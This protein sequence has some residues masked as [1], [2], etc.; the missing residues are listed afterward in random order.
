MIPATVRASSSSQLAHT[1]GDEGRGCSE[2][3]PRLAQGCRQLGREKGR[4]LL[5][6]MGSGV[7]SLPTQGR[8]GLNSITFTPTQHQNPSVSSSNLPL[9]CAG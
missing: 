9:A 5:P 3:E 2:P 6:E 7:P 8:N 1:A 4:F